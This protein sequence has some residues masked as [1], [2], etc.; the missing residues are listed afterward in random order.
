M[1][2]TSYIV[3][4][5]VRLVLLLAIILSSC[6]EKGAGTYSYD[7]AF[8]GRHDPTIIELTDKTGNSRVIVSAKYQGRVMTSTSSGET[9]NSYG[10][11]N[12]NLIAA[13]KYKKQFNPVGGEERFW[14]GPEG[15]QYSLYFAPGDSFDIRNWQVPPVIDTI[16]YDVI[17]RTDTS[18]V[19][20]QTASLRNFSG[21]EFNLSVTRR[22]ELLS[23]DQIEDELDIALHKDLDVVGYQSFSAIVNQ[24]TTQWQK[25]TGLMS[26][27]LLGMFTPSPST[28]VII[29][30]SQGYD[31]LITTDYFG[32]I[33]PDRLE[34]RDGVL[35]F[36]CDGKFRSKIGLPPHVTKS[37]AGSYD[38]EKEIL[39]IIR[40]GVDVYGNYVNS[41]WEIQDE[42]Y[43]GD[44]LNSYNDGPLADGTQLGPFYELES[45]SPAMQLK[46]GET[47]TYSQITCHFEGDEES[48]RS[49]AKT[50][51]GFDINEL[52]TKE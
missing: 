18:A 35:L 11:I 5:P 51:L 32:E 15:G 9:G 43:K 48:L 16:S 44:A 17:E 28:T 34:V 4:M 25:E 36:T 8:L 26:I 29:P 1:R 31:S 21:T 40:F 45:S 50:L 3:T 49:V 2:F 24:G 27:W 19:F 41:K 23:R 14:L 30:F 10:W 39:T 46:P 22:I 13:N 33:P 12:Y 42:P 6:Q 20:E 7:L 52:T 47:Q 37:Y 38:A